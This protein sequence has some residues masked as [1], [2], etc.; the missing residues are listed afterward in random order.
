MADDTGPQP[1]RLHTA[2]GLSLE[3]EV[4]VPAEAVGAAVLCHPHPLHGGSMRSLVPSEL[5]RTLP[6]EGIAVVRF[7]FRGVEGSEGAYGE[8]RGEQLDVV[9]ALEVLA[10]RAPGVP[11]VTAGWSFGADTSLAVLDERLAGWFCIAPTLRILPLEEYVAALDPRPKLLAVPEHDEFNPPSRCGPLVEGWTATEV[12][13]VP[14]AD[15][16]LVGRTAKVAA[17]LVAFLAD[18]AAPPG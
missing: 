5:F 6:A 2:D 7:N 13:V 9:A 17:W 15:H 18:L 14:G 16:Y 12:R 11:V 8:A 4:H 3:A 1:L 10:E